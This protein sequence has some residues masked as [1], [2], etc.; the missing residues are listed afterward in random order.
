VKLSWLLPSFL[1][2]FLFSLPAEAAKLEYWRFTADKNRLDLITDEGIQP[3]ALLIPNPTRLVIDLP[4]TKFG[5]PDTS[6]KIG[7]KILEARAAQFDPQTT[8]IVIEAAPGYTLTLEQVRVR[9]IAPNRWF[10][11]LPEPRPFSKER[12]WLTKSA[13]VP[14]PPPTQPVATLPK[15]VKLPKPRGGIVVVIDPG[16]GGQDS[17]AVGVGGLQEKRPILSIAL[18]VASLLEKQGVDA[19]LTRSDDRFVDLAPRV[20]LAE[21]VNANAF[22][23]IHA[24]SISLSRP[25]INGLETYRARSGSSGG[26]RLAQLIHNSIL[27]SV[28]MR[29][30]G[31]RSAGFYVLRNTS[32]PAVL[33]E[34]G[35]VTGRED[36]ARL[37]SPTGRRLLAQAIAQGILQYF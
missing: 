6:Q 19:V 21:R 4:N 37:A 7:G 36:A 13:T 24:N 32:M 1:G 16:H 3:K 8:R 11:Q 2:V 14:V 35:F 26:L 33:V 9:G 27:R 18:E 15:P 29:D 23:S 20:A 28:N 22:V 31:V 12:V 10:V 5:R 17:G 25:D 30:R 34:V